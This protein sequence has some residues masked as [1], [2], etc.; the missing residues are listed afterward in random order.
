MA[1]LDVVVLP[2][3]VRD[4]DSRRPAPY[5]LADEGGDWAWAS[6][7]RDPGVAAMD[8]L[9]KLIPVPLSSLNPKWLRPL[10][11]T[12]FADRPDGS[13]GPGRVTLVYTAAVPLAL[14]D[15]SVTGASRWIPILTPASTSDEASEVGRTMLVDHGIRI[16]QLL[17]SVL[18]F[19][20]QSL[21]ETAAALLFLPDYWTMPQLRGIYSAVWGYEQDTAGFA[22]WAITGTS[23]KT[24]AKGKAAP[25][26]GAAIS[27]H[28]DLTDVSERL[29]QV[30]EAAS[31]TPGEESRG[32]GPGADTKERPRVGIDY[33]RLVDELRRPAGRTAL[34]GLPLMG[35]AAGLV[36]AL[37]PTNALVAA[38][39]RVAYQPNRQG[40]E[41]AW[42][43]TV[44][45]Q[46]D[47]HRLERLYLPR[48]GWKRTPTM[49]I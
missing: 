39:A 31:A 38:A 40:Q 36:G 44:A 11:V 14:A 48:P 49:T 19:W 46:P 17:E 45:D 43:R 10:G 4:D 16:G 32:G 41:P 42:F 37:L 24:R 33:K 1:S 7:P 28:V 18:D 9:A 2:I 47:N 8:L 12:F 22:R 30:L 34:V 26:F 25:A 20:R 5:A 23:A 13:G 35:A 6:N 29:V 21:E 27:S 3:S 15:P